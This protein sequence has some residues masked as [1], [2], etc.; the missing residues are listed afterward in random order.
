ME[1][2]RGSE[3]LAC[4]KKK[5]DDCSGVHHR[6]KINDMLYNSITDTDSSYQCG[7]N[8]MNLMHVLPASVFGNYYCSFN[9]D[10]C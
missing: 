5:H 3:R 1:N 2:E 8:W 10:K 9:T 7:L 6:H 4:I